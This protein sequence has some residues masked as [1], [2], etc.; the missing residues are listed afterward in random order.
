VRN[1]ARTALRIA[2]STTKATIQQLVDANPEQAEAII[3]SVNMAVRKTPVRTKAA[4][5]VKPG[6][7]SGSA[8]LAVK[9]AA[10]RASYDWEWSGDGGHTWTPV[11]PTLQAKTVIT[12][13]PVGTT[14]QFRHRAVTKT[15]PSDWSQVITLVIK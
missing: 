2:L 5:A 14:C 11:A 6:A 10:N 7:I 12:G 4:F 15:G 3:G 8:Q 9:S 13:L 1:A